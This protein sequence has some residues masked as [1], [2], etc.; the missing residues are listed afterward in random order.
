MDKKE[1][2]LL[3]VGP[4]I[5]NPNHSYYTQNNICTKSFLDRQEQYESVKSKKKEKLLK[6]SEETESM[7]FTFTPIINS[8]N[9]YEIDQQAH[10]RLYRYSLIK[11]FIF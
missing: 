5:T 3:R 7:I 2:D 1:S 6:D 8:T 10:L 4:E 9:A 11:L